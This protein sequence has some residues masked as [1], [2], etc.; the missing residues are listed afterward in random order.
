MSI[1][2]PNLPQNPCYGIT[3][4]GIEYLEFACLYNLEDYYTR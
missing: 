3:S 4:D 2:Q 1:L